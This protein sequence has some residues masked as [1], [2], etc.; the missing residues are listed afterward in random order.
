MKKFSTHVQG[1]V[2]LTLSLG[3]HA[4]HSRDQQRLLIT[5]YTIIST[6]VRPRWR[7]IA[8]TQ[9]CGWDM[10]VCKARGWS[11]GEPREAT[12]MSRMIFICAMYPTIYIFLKFYH[13]AFFLHLLL[14][15][16]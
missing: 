3:R 4:A 7:S 10:M 15:P 16:T 12:R 2:E 14:A 11:H 9:P 8:A 13:C 5:L 6:C 1:R